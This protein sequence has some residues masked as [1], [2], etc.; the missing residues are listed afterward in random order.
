MFIKAMKTTFASQTYY[1]P[2]S[3]HGLHID[4]L[5]QSKVT[6]RTWS[7]IHK[8]GATICFDGWDKVAWRPLLNVM[9]ACPSGDVFI[10]CINSTM[11]WKDAHY[12]YNSLA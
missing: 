8:Y 1:K 11:E 10:G 4:M 6:K 3:Y 7:S 9:F 2:L 12:I 5:K